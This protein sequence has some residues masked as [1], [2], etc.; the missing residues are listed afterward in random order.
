V[1][2]LSFVI[3]SEQEEFAQEMSLRLSKLRNVEVAGIATEIESLVELVKNEL[4]D[5]LFADLGLAPHVILDQL[6]G[7]QIPLPD[8]LVCGSQDESRLILRAMQVG[9]KEFLP[10]APEPSELAT[11]V[12]RIYRAA[13][14]VAGNG[15]PAPVISVMGAKGG[16]GATVVACQLAASLQSGGERTVLIDLN[17]PLGDVALHFDVDP[18]HTIADLVKGDEQID[19]SFVNGILT[20]HSSGVHIL[21][22]SSNIE[23]SELVTGQD[24]ENLVAVL[25]EQFD[26][27]VIDVSRNWNEA[28]VRALDLADQIFVTTL[29]DVPT[30]HHAKKHMEL[31]T[32]LGHQPERVQA[33]GQGLHRVPGTRGLGLHSE[34]LRQHGEQR[35]RGAADPR[36]R[37]GLRA[38]PVLPESRASGPHLVWTRGT[39]RERRPQGT[40][41][42]GPRPRHVWKEVDAWH[43][44]VDYSATALGP[45]PKTRARRTS[46]TTFRPMPTRSSSSGSTTGSSSCSTWPSSRR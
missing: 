28:T 46:R 32:R 38:R 36:D 4:P 14:G 11:A 27:V 45:P 33:I 42:R 10:P 29:L 26:W 9:A 40:Q 23:D 1:R 39:G 18:E 13:Q 37:S 15:A 19:K 5:V 3:F 6:E 12:D 24:V 21:A 7:I 16:V 44:S 2:K 20:E 8:L 17:F 22:A 41:P 31:L 34:R 35:Q 25:R 43:C 30:L